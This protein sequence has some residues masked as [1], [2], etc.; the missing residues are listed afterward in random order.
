[1]YD[2][3]KTIK[4]MRHTLE[5]LGYNV[6]KHKKIARNTLEFSYGNTEYTITPNNTKKEHTAMHTAI[7]Y[8]DTVVADYNR[9]T[10][11][12]K[13][14]TNGYQTKTTKERINE[15]LPNGAYIQQK[16]FTW[17]LHTPSE[18]LGVPTPFDEIENKWIEI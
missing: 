10:D 12:Y 14:K 18:E 16:D 11:R 3:P 6:H 8:H 4:H 13:L 7:L 5:Q 1:M 15:A 2:K 9:T 17:Y